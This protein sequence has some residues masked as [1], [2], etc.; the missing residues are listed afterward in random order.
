M[1]ILILLIAIIFI[2]SAYASITIDLEPQ[3]EEIL[4]K[5]AE[6]N[7]MTMKK[8]IENI[9]GGWANEHLKG[10]FI[11]EMD[12]K[13]YQELKEFFNKKEIKK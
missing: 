12:K 4:Q 10:D 9:V 1:R 11:K 3:Q 2:P 13:T 8:Y 5:Y 6:A 7:Q